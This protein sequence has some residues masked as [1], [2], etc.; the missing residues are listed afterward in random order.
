MGSHPK[1]LP[2]I[3]ATKRPSVQRYGVCLKAELVYKKLTKT[4]VRATDNDVRGLNEFS[5][6]TLAFG[7]NRDRVAGDVHI[8]VFFEEKISN[9]IDLEPPYL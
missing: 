3:C 8:R 4:I 9:N 6:C 1:H 5:Y 2:A 7:A